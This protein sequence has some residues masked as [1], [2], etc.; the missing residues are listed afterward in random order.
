M[1][2][3]A[4]LIVAM[5]VLV[6]NFVA[7]GGKKHGEPTTPDQGDGQTSTAA[8]DPTMVT[9]DQMDDIQRM[10]VRKANAVSRC[11]SVAI[12]SK[13]LPKNSRGKVT[14]GVVISPN[15]KANDVKVIKATLESKALNE[16]VMEKVKEIQF[17]EIP[18]SYETTYTYAF[19]A[20]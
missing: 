1:V 13:D 18:K 5:S 15:G 4:L 8:S 20:S 19:E 12:D 3:H 6:G 17:P 16:C 9:A 14:L 11:L 10:F 7:C 2:K